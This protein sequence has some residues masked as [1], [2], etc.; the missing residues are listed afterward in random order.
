M[1]LK[2]NRVTWLGHGTWLWET[3]DNKRILIDAWLDGNPSCPDELKDPGHLDTILVTHGH[4]DH[5]G[6]IEKAA[7]S[8]PVVVAIFE[9][10]HYLQSI[11]I[12]N[13]VQMNK[14]GAVD[15]PGARVT[16]TTAHHSGGILHEGQHIDGGDPAGFI[17]EFADGL[18]VYHAGDTCVFGDMAL[19]AE[20]YEPSVVV[21]PIGDHFTMGVREAI[22]A[23]R[24]TKATQVL[25]GHWGTF[26]VLVGTPTSLQEAVGEGVEVA[27]L[28]DRKSVV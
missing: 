17:I 13:V 11:G 22:H 8:K 1:D 23:V 5:I 2:G 27:N 14:G 20:I 18:V 25:C 12:E 10:G 24:L 6:D 4:F 19:I 28:A 21:L 7:A 16:M 26:P 3:S 9:T 15:V